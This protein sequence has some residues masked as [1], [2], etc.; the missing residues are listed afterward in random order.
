MA[1]VECVLCRGAQQGMEMH[2][3]GI[4][5]L[6]ATRSA[7]QSCSFSATTTMTSKD[8]FKLT[9][10][11]SAA[12]GSELESQTSQKWHHFTQPVIRILLERNAHSVRLRVV[13][14]TE[15]NPKNANDIKTLVS[16]L[17]K[18][19]VIVLTRLCRRI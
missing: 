6:V 4:Q 18:I 17:S 9:K 3:I 19:F 7:H 11:S 15:T 1:N 14:S 10:F 2:V 5:A 16:S 8:M 12:F 13:W